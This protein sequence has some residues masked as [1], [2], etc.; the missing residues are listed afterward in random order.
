MQIEQHNIEIHENRRLWQNKPILRRLYR[1]FYIEIAAHINHLSNGCTIELGSGMGNVKE[2]IPECVTTDIFPN[3][4][5]N[6]TEN[7]YALSFND[8]SVGNLILFDVWHHLQFP[9]TALAE[10]GRVL[11][12][13]GRLILFEPAA[14]LLGKIMYGVFHHEP[15]GLKQP[16]QWYAPGSFNPEKQHYYAAQANCWRMVR[17]N[18]KPIALKKWHIREV[19]YYPALAYAASG[20]FRKRKLYPDVALPFLLKLECWLK[21][22]PSLFSTRMLVVMEKRNH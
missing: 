14:S 7:A 9:G 13:N 12:K 2:V 16:I 1:R 11:T 18:P 6:R 15:L 10:L 19:K 22:F 4:W 5:L 8:G 20:G 21:P 17:A 3:P